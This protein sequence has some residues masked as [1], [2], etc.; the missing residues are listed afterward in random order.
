MRECQCQCGVAIF[1]YKQTPSKWEILGFCFASDFG[2]QGKVIP[3]HSL[4]ISNNS[5]FVLQYV[6]T[7]VGSRV[8]GYQIC[9]QHEIATK[10]SRSRCVFDLLP[11]SIAF[12]SDFRLSTSLVSQKGRSVSA[13]CQLFYCCFSLVIL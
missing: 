3:S 10:A 12:A 8:D 2:Y 13:Q 6:L 7:V 1:R 5:P 9:W 11:R 4:F